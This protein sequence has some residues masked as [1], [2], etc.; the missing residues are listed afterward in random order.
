MKRV[1]LNIKDESEIPKTIYYGVVNGYNIDEDDI[2]RK[3][4][5]DIN[6]DG[7]VDRLK[8]LSDI[9]DVGEYIDGKT[10]VVKNNDPEWS[11]IEADA[12]IDEIDGGVV[13]D[14]LY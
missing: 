12:D 10:I 2:M 8:R 4:E 7:Y 5:Y 6:R 3:S 14:Q 9:D 11:D 13:Q 1:Y